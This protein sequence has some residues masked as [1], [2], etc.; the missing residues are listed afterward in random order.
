MSVKAHSFDLLRIDR[1]QD[2]RLSHHPFRDNITTRRFSLVLIS[3]MTGEQSD[4]MI[5]I[6][7][8]QALDS[9]VAIMQVEI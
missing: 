3:F 7:T 4:A 9:T 1:E 6:V 8:E 5:F 2:P